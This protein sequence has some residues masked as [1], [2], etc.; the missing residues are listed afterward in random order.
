MEFDSD[1][2]EEV[3]I[4][5][6]ADGYSVLM[7]TSDEGEITIK[8]D[9]NEDSDN[10][11]SLVEMFLENGKIN[12]I[13]SNFTGLG[14]KYIEVYGLM[15]VDCLKMN[16]FDTKYRCLYDLIMSKYEES[17]YQMRIDAE[18]FK[19]AY[20]EGNGYLNITLCTNGG[21]EIIPF[22]IESIRDSLYDKF[23]FYGEEVMIEMNNQQGLEE[24]VIRCG[25]FKLSF[26]KNDM[27]SLILEMID[28]YK[29]GIN[30]RKR[31]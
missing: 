11:S 27:F 15:Y 12:K 1:N 19:Y 23:D 22:E 8:Y 3:I 14:K 24:Y 13:L 29:N 30:K 5:E 7:T 9:K 17:R 31:R 21:K 16:V 25:E 28:D 6:V 10:V 26:P 2:F 4:E 20:E 18:E